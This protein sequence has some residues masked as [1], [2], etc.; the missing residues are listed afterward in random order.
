MSPEK[1]IRMANQIARFFQSQRADEAAAGFA[2][3]IN[4]FWEPRMRTQLFELLDRQ[5]DGF[6]PLVAQ[7]GSLI[8]RPGPQTGGEA[9]KPA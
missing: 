5:A 7:A 2:D 8:R 1:T 6:D 4:S 3:H 9:A